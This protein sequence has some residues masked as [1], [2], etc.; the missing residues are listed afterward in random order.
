MVKVVWRVK[1]CS[2]T[3]GIAL[4]MCS[5]VIPLVVSC[6]PSYVLTTTHLGWKLLTLSGNQPCK[7]MTIHMKGTNTERLEATHKLKTIYTEWKTVILSEKQS[8]GLETIHIATQATQVDQK[9]FISDRFE[10]T[11]RNKSYLRR[12]KIVYMNWKPSMLSEKQWHGSKLSTHFI[13]SESH[14]GRL[15]ATHPHE[16]K[17]SCTGSKGTYAVWNAVTWIE[18]HS[19]GLNSA[20]LQ[21]VSW[22]RRQH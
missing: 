20:H 7:L 21:D 2:S 19:H 11:P 18:N 16:L 10:D 17:T 6:L 4:S 5:W 8:R 12:L 13:S 22:V 15:K 14:F 1:H 3:C 9:W